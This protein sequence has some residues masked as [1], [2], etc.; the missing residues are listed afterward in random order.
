MSLAWSF[1]KISLMHL[2]LLDSI[3]A[4]ASN[5]ISDLDTLGLSKMAWACAVLELRDKPLLHAIA[6]ESLA[7]ID[8][9]EIQ[10]RLNTLWAFAD[11]SVGLVI[12]DL[13]SASSRQ[14]AALLR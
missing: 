10:D 5:K 11:L 13:L 6:S 14:F 1:A 12:Q 4:E 2:P 7:Q 8:E 3:A 9:F